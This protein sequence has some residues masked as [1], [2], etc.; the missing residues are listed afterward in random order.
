MRIDGRGT[1]HPVGIGIPKARRERQ[2][3]THDGG[4]PEVVVDGLGPGPVGRPR[5]GTLHA[6]RGPRTV[7][8][9]REA[10]PEGDD[11][12]GRH[13]HAVR[14]GRVEGAG[15]VADH[16]EALRPLR[17]PVQAWAA[18]DHAAEAADRAQ[19][20]DLGHQV[21][22]RRVGERLRVRRELALLHGRFGAAH[23]HEGEAPAPALQRQ[24]HSAHRAAGGVLA[25]LM[26][27][28]RGSVVWSARKMRV[29]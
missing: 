21:V 20:C 14:V 1:Q 10:A 18:I 11:A 3:R 12:H 15:R 26:T 13:G 29:A 19:G 25:T 16:H 23:T 2:R 22:Q 4:M 24:H 8:Q 7:A 6:P 5:D 27:G 28:T 17:Q 9:A